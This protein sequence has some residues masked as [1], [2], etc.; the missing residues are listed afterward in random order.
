MF[1][2]DGSEIEFFGNNL[3]GYYDNVV[4]TNYLTFDYYGFDK[5]GKISS[6]KFKISIA[7]KTSNKDAKLT[8][9][10]CSLYKFNYQL[11]TEIMNKIKDDLA[12]FKQDQKW[13]HGFVYNGYK[14]NIYVTIMWNDLSNSAV[15]RFMIGEKER[16]ILESD[17]V[18]VPIIEFFSFYEILNQTF[19]NYVNLC[20]VCNLESNIVRLQKITDNISTDTTV[21]ASAI[22]IMSSEDKLKNL[23]LSSL[24]SNQTAE[25]DIKTE[26]LNGLTEQEEKVIESAVDKESSENQ[27]SFDSFLTENRD[28]FELDLPDTSDSL[29]PEKDHHIKNELDS[30][31][32]KFITKVCNNDFSIFEQLIFNNSN[33][34]LPFDS[35]VKQVKDI[36]DIDFKDGMKDSDYIAVNYVISNTTKYHINNLLEKKIKLPSNITP[37]IIENEKKDDDK[38]D[39]MYYLL[40]FY[41]YLSKIRVILSEKT[42]NFLIS[43]VYLKMY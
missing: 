39:M 22:D 23:D 24:S 3:W 29:K 5:D 6:P 2:D 31:V 42:S 4:S 34:I 14:K 9:D 33:E 27:N 26:I 35:F 36:S 11:K 38:I 30:F 16:T 40:L 8:F 41:I 32:S 21:S 17:K 20:S 43:Q 19:N 15:I 10:S 13:S 18:Y 25:K 37:I 12:K 28:K 7:G 1:T